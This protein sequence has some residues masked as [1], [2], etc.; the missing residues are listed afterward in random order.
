MGTNE[1][2]AVMVEFSIIGECF[3]LSEIT[4]KLQIE[5]TRAYSKGNSGKF[6][7]STFAA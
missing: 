1:N 5:P 3:P 4:N 2:S 7:N 6:N